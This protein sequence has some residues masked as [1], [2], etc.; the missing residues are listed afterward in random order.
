[1]DLEHLWHF[2]NQASYD[3]TVTE[4]LSRE[5]LQAPILIVKE[6]AAVETILA[7]KAVNEFV[8]LSCWLL[9]LANANITTAAA[10]QGFLLLVCMSEQSHQSCCEDQGER[11]HLSC[12]FLW[13]TQILLSMVSNN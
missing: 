10:C 1:M 6:V 8:L 3:D 5:V 13:T 7:E 11:F 12:L 4:N 2:E 9:V